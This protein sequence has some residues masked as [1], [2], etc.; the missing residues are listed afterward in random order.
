MIQIDTKSIIISITI[1]LTILTLT[2][3][4][5]IRD[6]FSQIQQKPD[7]QSNSNIH[8]NEIKDNNTQAELTMRLQLEPHENEYLDDYYQISDFAFM[9]SNSSQLCPSGN[10]IYELEGG[11]MQAERIP[12]ERSLAGRITIETG[13]S[14]KSMELRASWKTIEFKNGENKVIKGILDLGTSQFSPENKYQIN[15][16]LTKFGENYLLEV[17][18]IK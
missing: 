7:F 10:C 6:G 5:L 2:L 8:K 11:T 12:G 9:L 16:T 17:E 13:D 1:M 3:P 18:G 15:G 14:K 4:E